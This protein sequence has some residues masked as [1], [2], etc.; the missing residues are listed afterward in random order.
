M[1]LE[2][3]YEYL[4]IGRMSHLTI[5]AGVSGRS[6]EMVHRAREAIAFASRPGWVKTKMM[7]PVYV[8]AAM[9]AWSCMDDETTERNLA[10]AESL[11]GIT[12]SRLS[13]YTTLLRAGTCS[14]SAS[15]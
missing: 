7:L 13:T 15:P 2:R 5:T 8:V 4:S 3:G 6:I 11:G 10:M 9:G 12:E 14:T 1:S